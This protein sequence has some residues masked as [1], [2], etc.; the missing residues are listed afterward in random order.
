MFGDSTGEGTLQRR[1]LLAAMAAT[2]VTLAP[3]IMASAQTDTGTATATSR[4]VDVTQTYP[5]TG[6]A[7]INGLQIYYEIHGSGGTPLLLLHGGIVGS[8]TFA[9]LLPGLSANRQVITIDLQGHGHTR[10]IDRPLR[11]ETMADDVAGVLAHLEIE[12]ADLLGYSMGGGVALQTA[13]RHP[14]IVRKLIIV[15]ATMRRDGS[16]PE[17][18]AQLDQLEANAP[19]LGAQVAQSPLATVYPEANWG[20]LFAKAG[21]MASRDYDWSANVAA[22]TAPAM[23]I[24]A[25]AD[26]IRPE[27]MVEFYTLL[28]G[29]QRDAGLDGSLRPTSRLAILPGTTHYDILT[30][31]GFADI[32]TGFLDAPLPDAES[33]S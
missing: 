16:Y 10:D 6:Y 29:G 33:R 2:G 30:F 27:H 9:P 14:E 4:G 17:V 18:L 12:Q 22:I 32:V 13:F 1:A 8:V 26:S 7:P 21:E 23:L 11:D 15:S 5:I 28:G 3:P 19:Q 24:F 31:P 25:D 20:T